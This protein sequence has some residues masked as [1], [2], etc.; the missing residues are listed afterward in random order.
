MIL[1]LID[2]VVSKEHFMLKYCF[3][4]YKTQ[5]LCD[6]AVDVFLSSLN[7]FPDRFVMNKMFQKL[8]N[9]VF[10]DDDIYLD[11]IDPDNVTF[12]SDG[13]DFFSIDHN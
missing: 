8:D 12:F 6:K 7:F 4:R 5:E 13:M 1:F 2:K 10:S 11:D 3:D 9:V